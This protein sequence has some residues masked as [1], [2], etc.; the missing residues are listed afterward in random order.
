M[1]EGREC[2]KCLS[3][4]LKRDIAGERANRVVWREEDWEHIDV[5][6]IRISSREQLFRECEKRG[7]WPVGVD[8]W[9]KPPK[10]KY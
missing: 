10:T 4:G 1:F 7:L 9:P 3:L 2:P 6:P 5:E 8:K